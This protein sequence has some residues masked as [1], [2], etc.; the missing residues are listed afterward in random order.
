MGDI[1]LDDSSQDLVKNCL[2][3]DL[4]PGDLLVSFITRLNREVPDTVLVLNVKMEIDPKE[5]CIEYMSV[6]NGRV[7]I[8]S[9][10]VIGTSRMTSEDSWIVLRTL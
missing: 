10:Y 2:W 9:T 7:R 1:G 8:D 6:K 4:R 3:I 5:M